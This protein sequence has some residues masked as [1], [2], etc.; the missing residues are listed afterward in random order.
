MYGN[1]V[2]IPSLACLDCDIMMLIE[3]E[4]GLY[5]ECRLSLKPDHC[6][7]PFQSMVPKEHRSSALE[8]I[9]SASE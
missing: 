1:D 4:Y 2:V 5:Y 3:S 7:G 8:P 6:D 9:A